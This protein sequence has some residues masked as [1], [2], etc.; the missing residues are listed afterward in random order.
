MTEFGK[1]IDDKRRNY[2][3]E[4]YPSMCGGVTSAVQGLKKIYD[5]IPKQSSFD[6]VVVMVTDGII[7][8]DP[9]KR[10]KVLEDFKKEGILLIE[11]VAGG[12]GLEDMELYGDIIMIKKDPV[13]LGIAIVDKL[14]NK[15]VLCQDDGNLSCIRFLI[16]IVNS[17]QLLS[18]AANNIITSLTNAYEGDDKRRTVLNI[19]CRCHRE[20]HK[21]KHLCANKKYPICGG[22]CMFGWDFIKVPALIYLY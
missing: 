21:N 13:D 9:D 19:F 7:L 11:A 20:K 16:I 15:S 5:V 10:K 2:N 14:A 4:K 22:K 8:D 3:S 1:C 18:N 17:Y 6:S 12:A